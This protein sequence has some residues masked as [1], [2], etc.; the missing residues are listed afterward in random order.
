MTRA[1][2]DDLRWRVITAVSGGMSA[3]A[4]AVRFGVGVSTAIVWARRHRESGE[5]SAR[6][7]GKRPG[8]KLDAHEA[9]ILTLIDETPDITLIEIGK[10]LQGEHGMSA[11]AAT[12]HGFL[13]K[14]GMT[15][16]KRP[17]TRVSRIGRM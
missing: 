12:L 2:S 10:R 17:R 5:R 14:R 9:F 13:A 11:C 3:R 15:F 7:Q 6:R 16:K 8:S 1:Y 4:A